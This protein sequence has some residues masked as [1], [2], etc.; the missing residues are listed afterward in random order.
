MSRPSET[1]LPFAFRP[2]AK[3]FQ[4]RAN[5]E[6]PRAVSDRQKLIFG[7]NTPLFFAHGDKWTGRTVQGDEQAG[8][9]QLHSIECSVPLLE[10]LQGDM[11]ALDRH[12]NNMADSMFASM[13]RQFF[14]TV[15]KTCDETGNHVDWSQSK[16]DA[17]EAFLA[18]LDRMEWGVDKDGNPSKPSIFIGPDNPLLAAMKRL[19]GDAEFSAKIEALTKKKQDEA[20]ARELLR[21]SKFKNPQ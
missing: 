20:L 9:F 5:Q 19:D 15:A 12:I 6:F 3:G 8:K 21:K 2:L 10:V 7:D 1:K 18:A 16:D 4:L 14:T 11:G 13:Q 17:G